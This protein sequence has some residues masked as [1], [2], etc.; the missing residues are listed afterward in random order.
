MC[1]F[2]VFVIFIEIAP[3]MLLKVIVFI[4]SIILS[5][6]MAIAK[7]LANRSK[8]DTPQAVS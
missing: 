4:I 2:E 7:L 3:S 1:L 5:Y 6:H 8:L